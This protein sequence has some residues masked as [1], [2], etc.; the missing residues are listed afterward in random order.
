MIG[1]NSTPARLAKLD[2]RSKEAKFQRQVRTELIAALGG[3]NRV[4][5]GQRMI[6]GLAAVKAL[7]LAMLAERIMTEADPPEEVDRRFTWFSNSLRRDL[8]ALGLDRR[9][10]DKVPSLSNYLQGRAA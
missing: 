6:V 3:E 9:P 5:F 8:Q 4:T 7:R 10:G 2:G 1:P